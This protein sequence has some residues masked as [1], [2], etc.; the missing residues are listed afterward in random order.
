M[1]VFDVLHRECGGLTELFTK[2]KHMSGS[3]VRLDICLECGK[4]EVVGVVKVS[5]PRVSLDGT[6]GAFPSAADKWV[7]TLESHQNKSRKYNDGN[8]GYGEFIT[9]PSKVEVI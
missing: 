6:S 9:K 1:K 2:V 3:R 7:K 4:K 5:A 8:P